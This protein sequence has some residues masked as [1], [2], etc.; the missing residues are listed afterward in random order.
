MKNIICYIKELICRIKEHE[1]DL[2]EYGYVR[3]CSRCKLQE[4]KQKDETWIKYY[5]IPFKTEKD[6]LLEGDLKI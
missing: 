2:Y 6:Y 3:V 5:H 4:E 1:F